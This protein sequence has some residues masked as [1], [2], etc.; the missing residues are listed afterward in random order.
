MSSM[1][2]F[3]LAPR[4]NG[5][6]AFP[7]DVAPTSTVA[8]L[9]EQINDH[10]LG[11]EDYKLPVDQQSL[12]LD[13]EHLKNDRVLADYNIRP[14][15]AVELSLLPPL[16]RTEARIVSAGNSVIELFIRLRLVDQTPNNSLMITSMPPQPVPLEPQD[17]GIGFGEVL[18]PWLGILQHSGLAVPLE[19]IDKFLPPSSRLREYAHAEKGTASFVIVHLSGNKNGRP[20]PRVG[21]GSRVSVISWKEFTADAKSAYF[22]GTVYYRPF[23][24]VHHIGTD[25]TPLLDEKI[26]AIL[27]QAD[28]LLG[29]AGPSASD[30]Y[31]LLLR[32]CQL[33]SSGAR[34]PEAATTWTLYKTATSPS[35]AVLG[36]FVAALCIAFDPALRN[37]SISL[38]LKHPLYLVLLAYRLSLIALHV[39]LATLLVKLFFLLPSRPHTPRLG[40]AVAFVSSAALLL[41]SALYFYPLHWPPTWATL[42]MTFVSILNLLFVGIWH[43]A[44]LVR[45]PESN[46]KCLADRAAV[47]RTVEDV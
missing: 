5:G 11:P 3:V 9:K 24:P 19:L 22:F 47:L 41:V 42:G 36:I 23:L 6:H 14:D 38:A 26:S 18:C 25:P 40:K 29:Q 39:L 20:K 33:F 45:H 28:A 8:M 44:S 37:T 1:R 12:I 32:N 21:G 4:G 27:H 46:A 16:N 7:L 2:V 10:I 13:G 35:I 17:C 31:N 43:W 15:S 34:G 30:S